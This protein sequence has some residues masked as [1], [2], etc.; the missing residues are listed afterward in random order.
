MLLLI[1]GLGLWIAAHVFKRMMPDARAALGANAGRGIMTVLII[2]AL[3]MMIFG[4]RWAPFVEIWTPPGFLTHVNNL[5]MII[6]VYVYFSTAALPGKVWIASKVAHP[7]LLGVKIWSVAH[8]LVN[9]DLASIILFGGLLGWAVWNLILIKR[10]VDTFDRTKAPIKSELAFTA[11][12]AVMFV[13]ITGI[14]TLA[15]VSPFGG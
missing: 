8:L 12:S 14:H 3:L 4:Y 9:G 1:A 10:G 6:A 13:V 15:G 2:G 11:V 7:Q 5:L